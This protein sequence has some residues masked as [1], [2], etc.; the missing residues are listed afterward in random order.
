MNDL[1]ESCSGNLVILNFCR[2]LCP[3][4]WFISC[5]LF[6]ACIL[7]WIRGWVNF[8][9]TLKLETMLEIAPDRS[10]STILSLT[11]EPEL[12]FAYFP[13][14]TNW[15][16]W[17]IQVFKEFELLESSFPS[18]PPSL[19]L[20]FPHFSSLVSENWHL[21]FHPLVIQNYVN[22]PDFSS[23]HESF[24]W[25]TPTLMLAPE[26]LVSGVYTPVSSVIPQGQ[27]SKLFTLLGTLLF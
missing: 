22:G 15:S 20:S 5:H 21:F 8:Y 11:D 14:W 9:N 12:H 7:A 17:P 26:S 16:I 23:R 3:S 27:V 18:F 6:V 19:S 4:I 24:L 2:L 13:W 1:I 25:L 10:S